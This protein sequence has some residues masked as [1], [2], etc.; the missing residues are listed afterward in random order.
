MTTVHEAGRVL[1]NSIYHRRWEIETSFRELKVVQ[2]MKELRGRTPGSIDYEIASHVLLYLLIRW[3]MVEAASER[4]IDPLRL[5]FTEA[6]REIDMMVRTLLTAS[7][8]RVH[9]VLLPRLLHRIASHRV[10]SRAGRHY[11]RPKDTQVKNLGHGR[12]QLPSKIIA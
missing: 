12:K 2:K 8:D 3:L 10:P 11:T 6:L 5:S 1:D 7:L 9:Q 4:G